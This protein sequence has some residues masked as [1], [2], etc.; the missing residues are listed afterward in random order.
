MPGKVIRQ[1]NEKLI[2]TNNSFIKT[3]VCAECIKATEI[4]PRLTQML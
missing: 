4:G 2:T 3:L 1:I